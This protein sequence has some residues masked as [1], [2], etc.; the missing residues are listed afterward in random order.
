M[1]L[2]TWCFQIIRGLGDMLRCH[3]LGFGHSSW[4]SLGGYNVVYWEIEDSIVKESWQMI[5]F[6]ICKLVDQGSECQKSM[7]KWPQIQLILF[8]FFSLS[9][10]LM[11]VLF[12]HGKAEMVII[13]IDFN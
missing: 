5:G 4:I 7:N 13:D 12:F 1:N 11:F 8:W 3:D 2:F 10:T 6:L 9:D